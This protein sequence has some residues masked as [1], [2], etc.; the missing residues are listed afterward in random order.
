[1]AGAVAPG[2]LITLFGLGFGPGALTHYEVSG[3][4]VTGVLDQTRV[5]FDGA[6]APLIFV[7]GDLIGAVVPYAVAAKTRTVIQVEYQGRVGNPVTVPV[8][9]AAPALIAADASGIGQ[10]AILN[11]NGSI[12]SMANPAR[13]GSVVMLY[14]TGEGATTPAGVDGRIADTPLPNPILPVQ[15][16]I[17][18]Q[19]CTSTIRRSGA[20]QCSWR[21]SDQCRDSRRLPGRRGSGLGH[22]RRRHQP[23]AGNCSRAVRSPDVE[24]FR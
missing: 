16:S 3:G 22:D 9:A 1:V 24:E 6:P 8:V 4:V 17:A 2:E 23:G 11:E 7:S 13:R 20:S 18:R 19:G 5:L 15:V 10:G 21:F 12:N 14:G